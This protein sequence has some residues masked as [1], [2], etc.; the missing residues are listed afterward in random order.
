MSSN[1]ITPQSL[2]LFSGLLATPTDE[3]LEIIAE[4]VQENLWLEEALEELR[5]IPLDHWQGEHTRLF[6]NGHPKTVCPPFESAYRY[7]L[8]NGPSCEQIEE[9]Y[10]TVGLE[11][12]EGIAPDY[13]GMMLECAAYLLEQKAFTTTADES[14]EEGNPEQTTDLFQTLWQTHLATWVPKF[15]EDLAQQSQLR[16]YQQLG[17]KLKELF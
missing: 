14:G 6:I 7:G 8:M 9:I 10:S 12:V 2:R 17:M 1:N 13:L 15:A 5:E 4:L 3:S 11:A 16:L